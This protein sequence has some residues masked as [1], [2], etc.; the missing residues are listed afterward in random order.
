MTPVGAA[1]QRCTPVSPERDVV[2]KWRQGSL[3]K[4]P[5]QFGRY[6]LQKRLGLGGMGSV[7]LALDT[8][9]DRA[10]ALKIPRFGV[11]SSAEQ[12]ER[13]L[14]EARAAGALRHPN[15]CTVYDVGQIEG[16]AYLTMSYIRGKLLSEVLRHERR[17]PILDSVRLVGQMAVAMDEAHR[18]G[19]IHRDLKPANIMID[20]RGQPMIMDFGLARRD[21]DLGGVRLTQCGLPLGTPA[22][23]SPEQVNGDIDA[24]GAACDIYSLGVILYEMLAGRLPFQGAVA[25]LLAQITSAP[26]APPSRFRP[27]LDRELD[28]ICLKALA[29]APTERFPSMEVFARAL[30]MYS[31]R[32]ETQLAERPVSSSDSSERPVALHEPA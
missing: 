3:I 9:L 12:K 6:I 28:L 25:I 22:Y 4:L 10:I 27:E 15:L 26:P 24:M 2:A 11:Y 23:M 29:K 21:S 20:D 7:Y 8:Q 13:F 19:I 1:E 17:R 18:H 31:Q 5:A 14:R 16:V 30:E 32:S